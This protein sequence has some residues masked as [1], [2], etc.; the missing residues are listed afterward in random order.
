MERQ[1]HRFR[2]IA[3]TKARHRPQVSSR[4]DLRQRVPRF[5]PS[6]IAVIALVT[7]LL[8]AFAVALM[9]QMPSAPETTHPSTGASEP[10]WQSDAPYGG[11]QSPTPSETNMATPDPADSDIVI[12]QVSG[13]VNDPGVVEVPA[14][15]RGK[16]AIEV[17]G[18]LTADAELASV[19]LAAPLVDGQH[20]HVNVVGAADAQRQVDTGCIDIRMA[21][22]AQLQELT[23]IGPAL[24]ARIVEYRT[25]HP[26]STASDL[27]AVSG[28]GAKTLQQIKDQLCP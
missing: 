26:L 4:Q 3:L 24:A 19:N 21:D 23:G 7:V 20:I 2:R 14:G 6:P 28:I 9:R 15:S 8:V 1:H 10:F 25:T 12:V 18:G 27:Q 16:D 13:A 11:S 5:F 17:A 22:E